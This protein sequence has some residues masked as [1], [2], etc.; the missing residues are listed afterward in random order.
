MACACGQR[1]DG[2][3]FSCHSLSK[4]KIDIKLA[5]DCMSVLETTKSVSRR[6][7]FFFH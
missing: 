5:Y 1:P 2:F 7:V 4:P 3:I 6:Y